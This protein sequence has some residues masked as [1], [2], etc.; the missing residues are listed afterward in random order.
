VSVARVDSGGA[1]EQAFGYSRAVRV[2]SRIIV[3]G[4]TSARDGVVKSPTDPAA[5][6]RLATETALAAVAELGGT[7][8]DVVRTRLYV[9]HRRDCEVIGRTHGELFGEVRPAATM[10]VVAGL[11]HPDMRVEIE[12]EAVVGTDSSPAEPV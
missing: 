3:S 12:V 11:L 9:T 5:Q 8:D 4:C 1:W 10:L 2:G 7:L 6:L